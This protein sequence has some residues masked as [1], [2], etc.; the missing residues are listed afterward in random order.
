MFKPFTFEEV[1]EYAKSL[2]YSRE[3]IE[4]KKVCVEYDYDIDEE[5]GWE[6]QVSFGYEYTEVWSWTF[7]DLDSEAID[8]DHSI[9]ED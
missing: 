3:D 8:Y 1:V 7:E 5:V 9:W 2:G 6:Y 4:I